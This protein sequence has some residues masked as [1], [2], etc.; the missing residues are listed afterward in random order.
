MER[1]IAQI[2]L[3]SEA[4]DISPD[5]PFTLASGKKSPIYCDNRILLGYPK[6]REEITTKF[7]EKIRNNEYD[8]IAGVA[9]GGISWAT[10][11]A[12]R[13]EK[14]LIYVRNKPKEHGTG[15]KIEGISPEYKK[16]VLIEDTIT[17]GKSAL[18]ALNTLRDNSAY[19]T[20]CLSVFSYNFPSTNQKFQNAGCKITAL[21]NLEIVL[22]ISSLPI[23][24]KQIV[25][26]WHRTGT[27]T[28]S[29]NS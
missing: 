5:K 27:T 15:N 11:I 19:V 21:T 17:T 14:P 28:K 3:E 25:R 8:I 9:T 22:R 10:L 29:L 16:V 6:A 2:L 1:R 12:E 26:D 7:I 18:Q 20:N 23:E 13:L 4:L 24:K